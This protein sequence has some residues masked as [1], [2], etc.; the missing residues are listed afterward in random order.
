[1]FDV[2]LMLKARRESKEVIDTSLGQAMAD[3]ALCKLAA[4]LFSKE[5]QQ[6]GLTEPELAAILAGVSAVVETTVAALPEK[7]QEMVKALRNTISITVV[8]IRRPD[9]DD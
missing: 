6:Q 1:M 4:M 8:T 3:L 9:D 5:F 7:A 2:G